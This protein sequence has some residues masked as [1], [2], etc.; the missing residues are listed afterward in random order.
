MHTI[1]TVEQELEKQKKS[2]KTKVDGETV[3]EEIGHTRSQL[4][5][6]IQEVIKIIMDG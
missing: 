1:E 6:Q 4:E 5:E 3:A 2:M